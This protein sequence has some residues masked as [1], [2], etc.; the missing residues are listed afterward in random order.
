MVDVSAKKKQNLELLLEMVLLVTD[1]GELKANPKRN[2]SGTVLESKIDR[3]RGPV[4]T[5]LVQDGTLHVGDTFIAGTIV[6]KV[7][8][9]IDDRGRSIKA[10]PP[11]TPVEVLGLGGVPSPGDAFQALHDAAKARQIALFRQE[12]AKARTLGAKSGRVTL[13]SLQQQLAEGSKDLALIIKADVQGSAEVLADSLAKLSTEKVKIK[14]IRSGVGAINESDVLLASASEAI[15]IGFNVRPDRN[16]ADLAD[17]ENVDIRQHSV[18]YA[19]ADEIRKAMEGLLEPT[20]KEA[21]LGVAAVR[22]IF[23]VPKY[24]T[25]AGCMVTDGRIIRSGDAQARLLRD[26]VVIHEGRIASL[27]RFKDDVSEVKSGF[28]CGIAFDGFNDIR[29]GDVIECFTLERVAA[30]TT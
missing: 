15:I 1:I 25:I 29:L 16:A 11:S 22:E 24:G 3:G 19:V 27:R 7:R 10:A 2:A 9:L 5:I 14:I 30:V 26:N 4:A 18:I 13:E 28:E 8:A 21:R 20:F 6:G 17:R 23:K 12:Q